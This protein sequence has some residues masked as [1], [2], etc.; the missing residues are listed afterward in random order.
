MN[1][2]RFLIKLFFCKQKRKQTLHQ[3]CIPVPY[4]DCITLIDLFVYLNIIPPGETLILNV[5]ISELHL[6]GGLVIL[7]FSS[8][9]L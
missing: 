5:Q 7:S 9:Y 1:F 6:W 4:T 3:F 8:C 2:K